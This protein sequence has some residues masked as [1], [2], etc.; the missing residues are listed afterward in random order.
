MVRAAKAAKRRNALGE[1][2]MTAAVPAVPEYDEVH[3]VMRR[4]AAVLRKAKPGRDGTVHA[5]AEGMVGVVVGASSVE[6]AISILDRLFHSMTERG[7]TVEAIG[8]GFRVTR[9]HDHAEMSMTERTRNEKH[10]ATPE[11]LVAE[12]RRI[13]RLEQSHAVKASWE[14][15]TYDDS[16]YVKAYPEYDTVL[17]GELVVRA[18][19]YNDGLRRTWADGKRQRLERLVDDIAVGIDVLLAARK[20]RREEGEER[21]RRFQE[22]MRRRRLAEGR[23]ERE[24]KRLA[25]LT[26]LISMEKTIAE[27]EGWLAHGSL[28]GLEASEDECGRLVEWARRRLEQLRDDVSPENIRRVLGEGKLFPL[29]DDLH[30]SLGEP[31]SNAGWY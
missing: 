12:E 10:V 7:L 13:K 5:T 6:R 2:N 1:S 18:E 4:S 8:K 30:D 23:A 19:G 22:L 11:E 15:G 17:A 21:E 31:P 20:V 28:S 14:A 3:P 25:L 16:L 24:K 29:P 9:G 27:L 26:E